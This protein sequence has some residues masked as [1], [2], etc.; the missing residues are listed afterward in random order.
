MQEEYTSPELEPVSVKHS[1]MKVF[2]TILLVFFILV[3][4]IFTIDPNLFI[5]DIEVTEAN[6]SQTELIVL[7]GEVLVN[8]QIITQNQVLKV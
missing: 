8:G 1:L 7:E 5:L 3:G 4:A 2:F 6:Y